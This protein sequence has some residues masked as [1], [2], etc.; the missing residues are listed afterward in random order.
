MVN[1]FSLRHEGEEQQ[2]VFQ[3]FADECVASDGT[4]PDQF[5]G[6]I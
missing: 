3:C 2:F 6:E 1:S 5:L 4:Q